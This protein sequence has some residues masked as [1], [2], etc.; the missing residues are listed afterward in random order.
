MVEQQ[1]DLILTVIENPI[2]RQIIKRLSQEPSYPLE[3]AKEIGQAQQLVTSHLAILEKMGLVSSSIEA[4]PNGPNR[5]MFYLKQSSSLSFS[6]GPHLFNEQCLNFETLPS[7]LS[8]QATNFMNRISDIQSNN[9]R[10]IEPFACLIKDIDDK[11]DELEAEKAVLLFIRNLAM[12]NV[13]KDLERQDKTHDER[14]ILHHILDERTKDIES[15]SK[16]LNLKESF[17]R[18]MLEKLSEE[19]P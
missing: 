8:S 14:R 17:V 11:L 10:K 16:A 6:F 2:R 12:K 18:M 1:I 13:V 9:K 3:L 19:I 4:S 5:K 15:I 7:E